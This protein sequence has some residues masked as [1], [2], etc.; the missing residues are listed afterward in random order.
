MELVVFVV[1]NGNLQKKTISDFLGEP[2]T[3]EKSEVPL[4]YD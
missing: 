1:E 2:S 3:S 4:G